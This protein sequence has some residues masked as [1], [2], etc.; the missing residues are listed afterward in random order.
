MSAGLLALFSLAA[1]ASAQTAVREKLGVEYGGAVNFTGQRQSLELDLY[2]PSERRKPRAVVIWVHGGGFTSGSS[3]LLR[4]YA[5]AFAERGY[6]SASINYRLAGDQLPRVGYVAA[7]RAAQ[8]DAQA[9]V[10]WFRRRAERLNVD[11]RKIFI[12]GHSAGAFTALEVAVSREDPGRSGNPGYSS[13]VR[14]A[15]GISGGLLD[16]GG[17]ERG[18]APMLLV[19]GDADA[20]VPIGASQG[21]CAAAARAGVSCR[22]V[23][24][25]GGG[26]LVP[27]TNLGEV[28]QITADWL[29]EHL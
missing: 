14:G 23:P 20:T 24:L 9:A 8:H 27:Y 16:P 13:R 17:I 6:I 12:G 11:P 2:R 3:I 29:R 26:H 5:Q 7:A 28:V 4:A 22:L 15:I 25:V 21:V 1:P 19:H 18:D 10:R